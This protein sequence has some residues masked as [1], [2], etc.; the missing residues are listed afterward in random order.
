[1]AEIEGPNV[2]FGADITP[3]SEGLQSITA[4][5]RES[6][7]QMKA[8]L[9]SLSET[10]LS[11][12][13]ANLQ[14]F[15]E[16]NAE[17][18][19]RLL[20]FQGAAE[21]G[22]SAQEQLGGAAGVAAQFTEE[23]SKAFEK[24]L[25]QLEP[26]RV[27]A[28]AYEE[29]MTLLGKAHDQGAISLERYSALMDECTKRHEEAQARIEG[30]GEASGG[31]SSAF[32]GLSSA[33]EGLAMKLVGLFALEKIGELLV[34]CAVGAMQEERSLNQLSTMVGI[35]GGDMDAARESVNAFTDALVKQGIE[36]T[37]S[38]AALQ[39]LL[40]VAGDLANAQRGVALAFDISMAT[41]K[42]LQSTLEGIRRLMTGNLMPVKQVRGAFYG[43]GIDATS[44][45]AAL[46]DLQRKFQ[47]STERM[48]DNQKKV[49]QLKAKWGEFKDQI[50]D[51]ALKLS[52]ALTPALDVLSYSMGGILITGTLVE[53]MFLKLG[54]SVTAMSEA[55]SLAAAGSYSAALAVLQAGKAEIDKISG[56]TEVKILE[57]TKKYTHMF[58]V[59]GG[60]AS[61]PPR[62]KEDENAKLLARG[63]ALLARIQAE[64]A[65]RERA[66]AA[67]REHQRALIE[68][69]DNG[70]QEIKNAQSAFHALSASDEAAYWADI[71]SKAQYGTEAYR[72]ALQKWTDADKAAQVQD[73][74]GQLEAERLK[75]DAT[76][77][78]SE[79]RLRIYDRILG[80]LANTYGTDS[81]EY[82][83]T[84]EEKTAELRDQAE[85]RVRIAT[86]EVE[87]ESARQLAPIALEE[88][89]VQ[90]LAGAGMIDYEA[91]LAA[92]RAFEE[93][94]YQIA[95]Q[96][97]AR[98]MM[99]EASQ[100]E[101]FAQ[102]LAELERLQVEHAIRTQEIQNQI[103]AQMRQR[104]ESLVNPIVSAFGHAMT[105]L[106][107][108]TMTFRQAFQ[109][110]MQSILQTF[111]N[112]LAQMLARW[113]TTKIMEMIIGKAMAQEGAQSEIASY[114]AIG[115]AAAGAS[116]AA[117]PYWGWAAAIPT[118]YTTY[119]ALMGFQALAGIG[120]AEKGWGEVPSDQ[121]AYLHKQEMVLPADLAEK[122]RTMASP[123]EYL[124]TPILHLQE[125][126]RS[127][128]A[129]A[130][131][132]I[133]GGS[134][135]SILGPPGAIPEAS[136]GDI[137]IHL[138]PVVQTL[139]A[140]GDQVRRFFDR[141]GPEMAEALGRRVRD[142]QGLR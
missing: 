93:Q 55:A 29:A 112:Y 74:E 52:S 60:D 32:D 120:V 70:L 37:A 128:G 115:G 138:T 133:S 97:L 132:R 8:S 105:G 26:A 51:F 94:R 142:F 76:E 38:R 103:W 73:V 135:S 95:A 116:V 104:V 83:K 27:E 25:D 79:D 30:T 59:A 36:D 20:D 129:E 130:T 109:S 21:S 47:G 12:F 111:I 106:I 4:Q 64:E 119:G 16:Q 48:D 42:D 39:R 140:S 43:M 126:I 85:E 66:L 24:L 33:V 54:A 99:L 107:Q 86:Q 68:T 11:E 41:G 136:G 40:P 6:A 63:D 35:M 98:R 7:E 28:A 13:Q 141:H 5:V 3:L 124:I 53:G 90:G 96:E 14:A 17:A 80:I 72:H 102:T 71:L 78:G 123:A 87:R 134:V 77:Q 15:V 122:V 22:I 118:A 56:Q 23:E 65:A 58:D 69:W 139:D 75:L 101:A 57:I 1:M 89:R 110:I 88:T 100:P 10:N 137:H 62:A 2:T 45:G 131:A 84:E 92:Q 114:A 91:Q 61:G 18:A 49:D 82:A 108:G 50:G 31:T 117:I 34:D 9:E 125:G 46:A 113:I 121:I 67:E 19:S 127:A 44:A 81:R